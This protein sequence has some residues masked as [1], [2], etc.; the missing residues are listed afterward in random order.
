[1]QIKPYTIQTALGPVH[2]TNNIVHELINSPALQRLKKIHQYGVLGSANAN[3]PAYSRYDHSL[4]VCALLQRYGADQSEQIA[5]I[6]HDASHTVFSHVAE[7]VFDHSS[8]DHSYQDNIHEWFLEK[9]NIPALLAK[10]HIRL[11]DILHKS[12][13]HTRLEQDLPNICADRLEYNLNGALLKK[14]ISHHDLEKL[15]TS[16][17][18]DENNWFFNHIEEAKLLGSI[19]LYL[20]EHQWSTPYNGI[21][22]HWAAQA[23]KQ[24]L[25]IG[26][27]NNDDIHF[28]TDD[29]VFNTLVTS[30]DPIITQQMHYLSNAQNNFAVH[31]ASDYDVHLKPKFRGIDPWVLTDQGLQR[32]THIDHEYAH[33]FN[34][35]KKLMAHGWYIKTGP[36][37]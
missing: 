10:H 13:T 24:A 33:A 15:L 18:F 37:I 29:V 35:T 4:G 3:T 17:Q 27:L 16:L 23:I 31:D 32:L 30:N 8:P 34:R 19:S 25:R 14:M 9:M 11:D 28:S 7:M 5:G 6:L 12:G 1:M 2:V 36:T 22:Y 21:A 26:L 20:N